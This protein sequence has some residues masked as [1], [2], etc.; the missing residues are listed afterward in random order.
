MD[1]VK[2]EYYQNVKSDPVIC[3]EGLSARFLTSFPPEAQDNFYLIN[4][5]VQRLPW[6]QVH[7]DLPVAIDN[8]LTEIPRYISNLPGALIFEAD[9][10]IPQKFKDLVRI[11]PINIA[12]GH[13][14][15]VG[16]HLISSIL[17]YFRSSEQLLIQKLTGRKS[18]DLQP[19]HPIFVVNVY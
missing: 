19:V 11:L 16:P 15:K 5:F 17:F 8:E 3:V 10:V 14:G 12:L 18:Y 1:S 4:H 7:Q 13:E 2:L 9:G 6:I